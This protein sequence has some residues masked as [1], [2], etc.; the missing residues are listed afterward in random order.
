MRAYASGFHWLTL[1]LALL[2]TDAR[3][4][5][6]AAQAHYYIGRRGDAFEYVR[7]PTSEGASE[8]RVLVWYLGNRTGRTPSVRY[9]DGASSGTLTCYDDCQFVRGVTTVAGKVVHAGRIRVTN[10]PLIYAI[11]HDALAGYLSK[12]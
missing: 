5:D 3:S 7:T 10:D 11:M 4:A 9:E 2:G 6:E 12:R 1:V 8:R